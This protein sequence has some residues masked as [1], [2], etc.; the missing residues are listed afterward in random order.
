VTLG[1]G[2]GEARFVVEDE[3]PGV[4]PRNFERIFDR[5][6]THRPG[7]DT[8]NHFGIGLW[9]VRRNVDAI[10]G[11]VAVDNRSERGLALTLILPVVR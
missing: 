8:T 7:R 10:G 11:R 9:V 6:F 2:A 3:G 5:Y 4:D 1:A